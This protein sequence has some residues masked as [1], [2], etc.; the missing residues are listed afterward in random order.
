M[1]K[2]LLILPVVLA[3]AVIG[4]LVNKNGISFL[5]QKTFKEAWLEKKA[6]GEDDEDEENPQKRAEMQAAR[7]QYEYDLLKDP[8]TGKIPKNAYSDEMKQAL[9]IPVS[10]SLQ[11]D[12]VSLGV[13]TPTSNAYLKA[14]PNN[15]GGRTRAFVLDKRFN[16]TSNQII[17]AGCVSGGIMRSAD[18]GA[19]WTMVTPSS[20]IHSLTTL[21]QDPRAGKE[22]TW[23]AG[24]GEALGNSAGTSGAFFFGNGVFK[25]T[26]N[27]LSWTPLSSTQSTLES[28]NSVFDIIHKIEVHPVTGDVYVAAQNSIQR[29][30]NGGT[31]WTAV[32]GSLGGTTVTGNTDVVIKADGSKIYIAFHLKNTNDRGVWESATGDA[33]SWTAIAGNTAETLTGEESYWH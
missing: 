13:N 6:E 16:G 14:G 15:I 28:F 5:R 17:I 29:S 21:A 33:N 7:W 24:S 23:Y 11:N 25:S 9:S 4:L 31:T 3:L 30:Q 32:K 1:K 10:G 12:V 26:D 20:Q 2:K 19:T 8:K 18:G 22:D 27:G